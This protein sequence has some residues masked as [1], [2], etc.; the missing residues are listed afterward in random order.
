VS[1]RVGSLESRTRRD[2][3][4]G[5]RPQSRSLTVAVGLPFVALLLSCGETYTGPWRDP[6]APVI[7]SFADSAFGT[8]GTK[9]FA[10]RSFD[11]VMAAHLDAQSIYTVEAKGATLSFLALN[12]TN[13]AHRWTKPV[14]ALSYKIISVAN[15]AAAVGQGVVAFNA[16]TGDSV[17]TYAPVLARRV[18]S[19]P[20]TDGTSIIVGN[21]AGEIVG[22]N[23]AT[24]AET[25]TVPLDTAP[26]QGVTVS[27]GV[28]FAGGNGFLAA[29]TIATGAQAWKRITTENPRPSVFR[30]PAVDSGRV[31]VTTST[32]GA[33]GIANYN[34]STG[35]LGWPASGAPLPT[36]YEASGTYAC[37]GIVVTHSGATLEG[38]STI[39]GSVSWGK[40]LAAYNLLSVGCANGTIIV[41]Q[42]LGPVDTRYNDVLILNATDAA[43]LAQYPK[44]A[45]QQLRVHRVV[46]NASAIYFFTATGIA[47]ILAP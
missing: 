17:F 36:G 42:R 38:R 7:P 10:V 18:T 34:A 2:D 3:N 29:V 33:A 19:N 1:G 21:A 32:S 37:S 15:T 8:G 28:V 41:N 22:L 11:S 25:W 47:A 30:A 6:N 43:V 44:A 26:V 9:W 20:A 13:G 12:I 14:P 23:P 46:R 24:G 40:G 45:G 35:V 16:T 31:T 5:V 39:N 4:R 27:G